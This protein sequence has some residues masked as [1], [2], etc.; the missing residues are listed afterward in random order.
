MIIC[1]ALEILQIVDN[2]FELPLKQD[3]GVS[4]LNF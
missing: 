1:H 4:L 2:Q 3:S